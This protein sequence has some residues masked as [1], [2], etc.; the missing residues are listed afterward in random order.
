M[1][2]NKMDKKVESHK[3]LLCFYAFKLMVGAWTVNGWL[4]VEY[5]D[6]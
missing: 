5:K 1:N 4:T 6:Q 3:V 2:L